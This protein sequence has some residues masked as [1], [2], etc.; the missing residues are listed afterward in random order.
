MYDQSDFVKKSGLS[1]SR[2]EPATISA[3]RAT[4]KKDS[5][6]LDPR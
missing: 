5:G 3:K 6:G 2:A 1:V 4:K